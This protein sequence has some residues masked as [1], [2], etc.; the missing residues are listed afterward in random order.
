MPLPA[1][2]SGLLQQVCPT[3]SSNGAYRACGRIRACLMSRSWR[4]FPVTVELAAWIT[5]GVSL[6]LV[7]GASAVRDRGL[8]SESGIMLLSL[9]GPILIGDRRV[10]TTHDMPLYVPPLAGVAINCWLLAWSR[11]WPTAY[12]RRRMNETD[13]DR[14][15]YDRAQ[16]RKQ[17]DQQPLR[18]SSPSVTSRAY[19]RFVCKL[20]EAETTG[21]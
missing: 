11:G 2:L 20:C 15:G 16:R 1:R 18:L 17:P 4:M 13:K 8:R 14:L 19:P 9:I 6:L 21:R 7:A 10:Q 12:F 3:L 5:C